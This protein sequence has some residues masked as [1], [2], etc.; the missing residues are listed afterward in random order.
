MIGIIFLNRIAQNQTVWMTD[1]LLTY[2]GKINFLQCDFLNA[3]PGSRLG[4]P[5]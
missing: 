4:N 1:N 5:L 3:F 2:F